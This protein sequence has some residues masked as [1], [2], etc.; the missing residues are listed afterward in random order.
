M[1]ETHSNNLKVCRL[2][3]G[4]GFDVELTNIGAR[5]MRLKVDGVDVVQGFERPEDYLP[6]AHLSDFGAVVG[7]YANRICGGRV[8]IDGEVVQLPQN[9]GPNCL[10]GG[11]R[12]WQY[13]VYQIV[14]ADDRHVEMVLR[15]PDGDNGFPGNVDVRV[16]YTLADDRALRI[17]YRA[18]CDKPT[19][20][21]MTNH[22]YFNLDGTTGCTVC[23]SAE[24][25]T[26]RIDADRYMPVDETMIPLRDAASVDGS[27]FDF[28]VAKPIGRDIEC[29]HPQLVVGSGYDQ[30]FI[31]NHP[32]LDVP[33][34]VLQGQRSGIVMELYTTAP[35]LQLYTGNFLDGVAGRGGTQYPRRSAVCLEA[36]QYPDSPNRSWP[37]STGRLN[38]GEM[39]ESTT[40]FKFKKSR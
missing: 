37:E 40:I 22:S 14:E 28:R 15:S 13:S 7:R 24:G 4:K 21:N 31:L 12:G 18:V 5:I 30:N 32:G 8:V 3:D 25:H 29:G 27:P 38:P 9:N 36:Q 11:P 35:G 19:V 33:S 1:M 23:P 20:I 10:H 26:L 2:T 17:D 39:F 34:A 16:R 6:E